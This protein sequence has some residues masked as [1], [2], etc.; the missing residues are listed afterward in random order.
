M[1]DFVS[2]N[3]P[4]GLR[5]RLDRWLTVHLAPRARDPGVW[6]TGGLRATLCLGGQSL[7]AS[8]L[9]SCDRSGR[10]FPLACCHLPGMSAAPARNW[11]DAALPRALA[12][13]NGDIG[14]DA[15][16]AALSDLPEQQEGPAAPGFWTEAHPEPLTTL[17]DDA[18]L[19]SLIGPLS[20][21]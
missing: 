11:C 7:T 10:A 5:P 18:A 13:T 12:G 8:I 16:L 3:L 9:P 17:G 1:G 6:P 19:E 2:R 14:A 4:V 20:S 21:G 15:L